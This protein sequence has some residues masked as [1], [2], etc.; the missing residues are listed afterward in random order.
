MPILST[1]LWLPLLA[2][3]LV[4]FI[5]S[6][7]VRLIRG[8]AHAATGSVL[9]LVL[10]LLTRFDTTTSTLQFTELVYWNPQ[11]GNRYALGLDGLSLPMLLLSGALCWVA[12]LVSGS[13]SHHIKGYHIALLILEFGLLGVFLAQD[14]VLFCIAWE[15]TLIALFVLIDRWGGATR[16]AASLNFALY[17]LGGSVFMLTALLVVFIQSGEHSTNLTAMMKT[18]QSL[19]REQQCWVLLGLCLGFGVNM[20]VFPLHGWL[21][22]AHTEAPGSI[23]ILLSG[24]LLKMGAYGLLRAVGMLPDAALVFQ[25]WLAGLALTGMLYGAILALHQTDLRVVAAYSSV[26]HMASVLLGIATL[27]ETGLL[28]ASLQMTAH[29]LIAAILFLLINLLYQPGRNPGDYDGLIRMA[30]RFAL[31]LG[32]AWLASMSLPGTA[33]FVAELHILLGSLQS[34]GGLTAVASLASLV[35]AVYAVRTTGRLWAD[36]APPA[37]QVFSD[38][39]RNERIAAGLLAA[40]VV[41]P[42]LMPAPLTSLMNVSVTEL[43]SLFAQRNL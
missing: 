41:W 31:L 3:L 6:G 21:P 11:P 38:L 23:N 18:A 1:I 4:V 40:A 9:L 26:S 27:N 42:G 22:L 28:G 14:W 17:T 32:L 10:F 7:Q 24:V 34:F 37:L 2:A 12:V 16:H 43:A 15:I 33:G 30:P 39:N 8:L 19:P 13:V 25:P 20:P 36:P 29:G 5:P 35:G